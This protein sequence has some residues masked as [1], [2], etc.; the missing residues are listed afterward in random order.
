MR[1]GD[2]AQASCPP[3]SV[4]FTPWLSSAAAVGEAS[5]PT[6]SRSAMTSLWLSRANR[7]SSRQRPNQP[8]PC[9]SA[10]CRLE[11]AASQCRRAARRRSRSECRA[12]TNGADGPPSAVQ[13][14]AA[15]SPPTLRPSGRFGGEGPHGCDAAGWP[16]STWRF[17]IRLWAPS[18]ITAIPAA[19]PLFGRAL[20][21]AREAFDRIAE[22]RLALNHQTA[23][24]MN[25]SGSKAGRLRLALNHQTAKLRPQ[26]RTPL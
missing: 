7:P 20:S 8:T 2:P 4:V 5:R 6:R 10:A 17:Q 13:A 3:L 18:G 21:Y 11:A 25:A 1:A 12:A 22:L 23:K 16:G 15:R 26:I 24:L 14:S 19:Q 9:S